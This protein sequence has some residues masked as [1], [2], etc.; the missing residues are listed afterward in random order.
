MEYL[1][2]IGLFLCHFLGDFTHLSTKWMLDAKKFGKPLL[3]ILAHAGVHTLL[4]GLFLFIIN[5]SNLLF[6]IGFQLTTHFIIDVL[7]GKMN[8]WFPSLLDQT[9]KWHWVMFGADQFFHTLVIIS[10]LYISLNF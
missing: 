6:L 9:N 4:M 8:K 1:I 3:P 7:K 5:V 10:M 2:L